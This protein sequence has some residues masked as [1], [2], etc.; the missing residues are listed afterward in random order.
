MAF[1]TNS[2]ECLNGFVI[3]INGLMYTETS[4]FPSNVKLSRSAHNQQPATRDAPYAS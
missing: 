3:Q 1:L 4:M 2:Y